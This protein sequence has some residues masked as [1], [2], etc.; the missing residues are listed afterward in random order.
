MRQYHEI[1][2]FMPKDVISRL[3][4]SDRNE[5][6][7]EWLSREPTPTGWFFTKT[8]IAA[9][10]EDFI[11][12]LF[13]KVDEGINSDGTE[14]TREGLLE[15]VKDLMNAFASDINILYEYVELYQ[16]EYPEKLNQETASST[17]P[18]PRDPKTG[19]FMKKSNKL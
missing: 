15:G 14:V 16:E 9:L 4:Q 3:S 13:E 18:Q 12:Y 7:I 5:M 11:N 6:I 10:G 1:Y 19:R 8:V 2:G 17:V